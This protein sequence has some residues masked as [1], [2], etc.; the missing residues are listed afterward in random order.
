MTIIFSKFQPKN[1]HKRYFSA[2]FKVLF[3]EILK[4]IN[5]PGLKQNY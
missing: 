5:F 4:E 1:T 2:K 3:Y